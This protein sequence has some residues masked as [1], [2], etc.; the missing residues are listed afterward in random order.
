MAY[1]QN[2]AQTTAR[3]LRQAAADV[4]HVAALLPLVAD[5]KAS[6]AQAVSTLNAAITALTNRR[7]EIVAD[8]GD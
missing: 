1:M 2:E 5:G 4:E 6:G 3:A 7:D 8:A